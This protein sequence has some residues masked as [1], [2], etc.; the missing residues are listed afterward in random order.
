MGC[1]RWILSGKRGTGIPGRKEIMQIRVLGPVQICS[2]GGMVMEVGPPQRCLVFAAL[3]VD[4][5]GLHS[6]TC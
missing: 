1:Q 5:G 2:G 4:A 3:A 6:R